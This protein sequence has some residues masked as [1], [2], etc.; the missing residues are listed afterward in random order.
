VSIGGYY[1]SCECPVSSASLPFVTYAANG[2][3][4]PNFPLAASQLKSVFESGSFLLWQALA[5][6]KPQLGSNF[7][8]S[9]FQKADVMNG[10]VQTSLER[11]ICCFKASGPR[12]N[13]EAHLLPPD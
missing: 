1:Q 8:R 9:I 13:T 6:F 5:H 7:R 2:S 12:Q 4:E 11:Y 10:A 3:T